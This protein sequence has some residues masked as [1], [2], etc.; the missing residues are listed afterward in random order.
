VGV[1]GEEVAA[2][3]HD[4]QVKAGSQLPVGPGR[5]SFAGCTEGPHQGKGPLCQSQT[6]RKVV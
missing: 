2:I 6:S 3:G 5:K 4:G 1:E